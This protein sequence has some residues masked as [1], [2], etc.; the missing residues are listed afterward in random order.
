MSEI[1]GKCGTDCNKCS[2]KEKF[3]CNGCLKQQG[4]IF[5]G[6][7]AIYSC[8]TERDC[9]H[10]GHCQELPCEKLLDFIKNGHNP[11]RL[12]NLNRWKSEENL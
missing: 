8:A 3:N 4:K 7:C 6:E 1:K 2:F 9:Q 5:W 12:T 11:D 10:C